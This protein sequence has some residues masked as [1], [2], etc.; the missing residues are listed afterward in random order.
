MTYRLQSYLPSKCLFEFLLF[1]K[2]CS[3]SEQLWSLNWSTEI[4]G[5]CM[6]TNREMTVAAFLV[7]S[8]P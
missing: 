6:A 4:E 3:E 2:C 1:R 8:Y 5:F 7:H